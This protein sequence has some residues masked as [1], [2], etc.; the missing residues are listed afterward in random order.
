MKM[1]FGQHKGTEV[2]D[3]ETS[4]IRWCVGNLT[5]P[6]KYPNESLVSYKQRQSDFKDLMFELEEELENR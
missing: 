2:A 3:L 1:P 5:I 6:L 4:Y